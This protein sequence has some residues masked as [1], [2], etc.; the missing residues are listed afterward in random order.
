MLQTLNNEFTGKH[1]VYLKTDIGKLEQIEK[2]F[3]SVVEKFGS[4]D[5]VINTAGIFNEKDVNGTLVINAVRQTKPLKCVII[6]F[7]FFFK[8]FLNVRAA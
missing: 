6:L 4:V 3:G 5:V 7:D 2:A 8:S 1:I